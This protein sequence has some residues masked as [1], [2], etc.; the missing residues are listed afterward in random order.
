MAQNNKWSTWQH[1]HLEGSILSAD[2]LEQVSKET[3]SAQTKEAYQLSSGDSTSEIIGFSYRMA[4][5]LYADYEKK[6][7]TES[8]DKAEVTRT[9]IVKFFNQCLGWN[10]EFVRK[11]D[12]EGRSFPIKRIAYEKI[13]LV[14][15]PGNDSLDKASSLYSITNGQKNV[16]PFQMLQQYLT[17]AGASR[18][19]VVANGVKFRLLR[20]STALS[21]PQYLEFDL[22]AILDDD[23]YNEYALLWR[24][25]HFSRIRDVVNDTDLE[26]WEEWRKTAIDSGERVRDRLRVGVSKAL[27]NLGTGF[28]KSNGDLRDKISSGELSTEDYYH[29]LL[30]LVY[31]FLFL[32][33][34]EERYSEKGLRIIFDPDSDYFARDAYDKGYSLARLKPLI[35][36]LRY[37]NRQYDLYE[38]QKV[39]F[40]SLEKGE[41]LLGLPALGGM[42][43]EE[44]CR[45]IVHLKLTND[46]FLQTMD[47]LRW[48]SNGGRVTWIDYKNLGT[49]ELGSVYESLL[50]MVPVIDEDNWEFR[51]LDFDDEETNAGNARKTSGSYYTPDFLVDQLIKTT[52]IPTVEE[53]LKEGGDPEKTILS[54]SLVDPACGSGHFLISAASTLA[55]YL[56]QSRGDGDTVTGFREAYRDVISSCIYGV[57]INPM[58]VEL[59]KMALWLEGY[60]PGKPLSFLDSHIKCG[61]SLMGVFD[62]TILNDGIPKAAFEASK[63]DDKEI[64]KELA[65]ATKIKSKNK[66]DVSNTSYMSNEI[67]YNI[68]SKIDLMDESSQDDVSRKKKAYR[69]YVESINISPVKLAADYYMSAFFS[70]KTKETESSIPNS[71]TLGKLLS[72]TEGAED[73]ASIEY[74]KQLATQNGYFHWKLEFPLVFKKGGF[75][76][77]LGNPPWDKVKLKDEEFFASRA[78]EISKAQNSSK[79]KKL[80]N[81]LQNGNEYKRKIYND[82]LEAQRSCFVQSVFVHMTEEDKGQYTLSGK[83]DVNMYALFAELASKIA[84]SNGAIGMVVPTGLTT[85]DTAKDLFRDFVDRKIV[86]SVYDFENGGASETSDSNGKKKKEGSVIFPAVHRSY[87]FCLLTLRPSDKPDFVFFAHSVKDL[88]DERRHYPLSSEDIKMFNPNTLTLP[89]IRSAKDYDLLKKIYKNSSVVWDENKDDGNIFGLTFMR[90]FDMSTDAYLFKDQG[91]PGLI[92]LYEGKFISQFDHRYNSYDGALD[93]DGNPTTGLVSDEKKADP[94][95]EI[96]TQYWISEREVLYKYS[97]ASQ[98]IKNLWYG[99][100]TKNG[101]KKKKVKETY[102]QGFF[103]L[104]DDTPENL[105]PEQLDKIVR[106]KT[107]KWCFGYRMIARTTDSRTVIS[108]LFPVSGVGNSMTTL[109][110]LLLDQAIQL[111]SNL[112]SIVLDYAARMKVGGTNLSYFYFK[113]FP[114]IPPKS[115]KDE[116]TAFVVSYGTKLVATSYRMAEALGCEVHKYDPEERAV[117]RARLDAFYAKKY[118]LD[119]EDLEF[120]LDPKEVMGKDYP[121]ETFPSL[122]ADEIKEYGE[123]KT[124]RLIL[125]AY[126]ELTTGGLWKD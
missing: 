32:F 104:G 40:K 92:P 11:L 10:I 18:W 27:R 111:S 96:T 73:R 20:S 52:L 64:C 124:K 114:V 60:E 116:E 121:T 31:R 51:F 50:E 123:Y 48:S 22:G 117:L 69:E 109:N 63:M 33:V 26:I 89:L 78:P 58:A 12:A 126:D 77:V 3:A 14:I 16:S 85:D 62:L 108:S 37:R 91:G 47:N 44:F 54:L 80:I 49:Q 76:I 93:S 74:S 70:K 5:S 7:N 15:V 57:D 42:F 119:R 101:G 97:D 122:K 38:V 36:Q 25:L 113:Q 87:K 59:T 84:S 2:V 81:A 106:E 13:P 66:E 95:Y 29:E 45:D 6:I 19:G 79:R 110:G 53:K 46:Y 105:S 103:D 35:R 90:M 56:S 88:E 8:N 21:R 9:F 65:K 43:G 68:L 99:K 102:G 34:T 1:V 55:V 75:D 98:D 86:N 30:R 41:P 61:N 23:F 4:R 83:K 115:Y 28:L 94:G 71:I 72:R 107:R 39:V 112:S 125:E 82:Y 17:A 24:F 100:E 120:I 67:F 118:S